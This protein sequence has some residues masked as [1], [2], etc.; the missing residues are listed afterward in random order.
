[1]DSKK[2]RK[3]RNEFETWMANEENKVPVTVESYASAIEK[4]S[5]HYSRET[6][7]TIDIYQINDIHFLRKICKEYKRSGR[8]ENF[9]DESH[10]L[11][12]A[13][14]SAYVRYFEENGSDNVKVF[15]EEKHFSI[16][17]S[18]ISVRKSKGR[19]N[20]CIKLVVDEVNE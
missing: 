3:M 10:G 17:D 19:I 20:M 15:D 1:M 11:Y 18:N 14:I 6:G 7:R 2:E 16:S 13:A 5:L 8:F 12:R 9:G 4:I